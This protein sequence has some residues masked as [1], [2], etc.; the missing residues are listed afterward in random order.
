MSNQIEV[1]VSLD[2]SATDKGHLLERLVQDLLGVM[3][4]TAGHSN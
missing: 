2:L 3:Q 4:Y 1:A